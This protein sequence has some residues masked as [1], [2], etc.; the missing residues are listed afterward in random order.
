[1]RSLWD[2]G[3]DL[4]AGRLVRVLPRYQGSEDVG[5][6]AVHPRSSLVPRS[7]ERFLDYLRQLY[8]TA[9]PWRGGA[10]AS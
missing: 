3:G 10:E 4:Q 2:V 9:P 1:L 5:V 6:Y 8:E 7:A